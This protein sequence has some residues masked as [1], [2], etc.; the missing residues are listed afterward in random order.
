MQAQTHNIFKECATYMPYNMCY[1]ICYRINLYIMHPTGT[2][3][4]KIISNNRTITRLPLPP[5]LPVRKSCEVSAAVSATFGISRCCSFK[6]Q[7]IVH[8]V[9]MD[10][11]LDA[12]I[13]AAVPRVAETRRSHCHR[14]KVAVPL[15]A[16]VL[17][18]RTSTNRTQRGCT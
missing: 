15:V 2:E 6:E 8:A 3:R 12:A 1:N 14:V 13:I 5:W 16:T 7:N 10:W 9:S 17:P 18:W 11:T 4:T